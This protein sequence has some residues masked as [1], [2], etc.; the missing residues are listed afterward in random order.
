MGNKDL[1]NRKTVLWFGSNTKRK[2]W[3]LARRIFKKILLNSNDVSV[4][5]VVRDNSGIFVNLK[6]D[7]PHFF[8]IVDFMPKSQFSEVVKVADIILS[9][10]F[11]EV[12]STFILESLVSGK[13]VLSSKF[14]GA[15]DT[16]NKDYL[17][18]WSDSPEDIANQLIDK[19]SCSDKFSSN[20]AELYIN[21]K[22]R[23]VKFLK[24]DNNDF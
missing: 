14:P 7:F 22:G 16:I 12:N 10:S 17:F 19:L 8:S 5:A 18:N 23:A 24:Y 3:Y 2:N 13:P 6:D 21:Q 15:F 1:K 20:V 4:I 9:T 11:R